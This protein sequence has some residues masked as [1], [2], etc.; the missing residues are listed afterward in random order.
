M[1]E[2]I[3]NKIIPF[4]SVDG[5]GNRTAI[6]LQ[7]CNL[8]CIY[9]HNPETLTVCKECGQCVDVCLAQALTKEGEQATF[10]WQKDLCTGCDRCIQAC[11]HHSSPRTKQMTA[12]D[13]MQV[14]LPY[15]HF[16]QGITVS[17]G[18]CTLQAAFVT[19]LFQK[20]HASGLNCYL[21]TNGTIAFQDMSELLAVTDGVMLDVKVWDEGVHQR[22]IGASNV[23]ILKNL[24]YLL[25]HQKLYEVRTVIVPKLFNNKETVAD[26]A[27]KL[28]GTSVRYKLIRYRPYGVKEQAGILEVPDDVMMSALKALA[29]VKGCKEVVVV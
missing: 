17:G 22:W 18:E 23:N 6:F 19:E 28:A 14:L 5:P 9:C 25:A 21:D 3:I 12:E 2:G 1:T 27:S 11:P 4:S 26:V 15:K 24:D 10:K 16:I 8:R 7:G 13:V 20:A 29:K